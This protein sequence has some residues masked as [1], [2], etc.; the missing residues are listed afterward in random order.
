MKSTSLNEMTY[1][2]DFDQ[3]AALPQP[4]LPGVPVRLHL[5][6]DALVVDMEPQLAKPVTT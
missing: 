2:A 5:C 3:S 1:L 6:H 4:R